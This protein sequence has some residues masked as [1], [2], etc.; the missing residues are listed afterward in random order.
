MPEC[1]QIEVGLDFVDGFEIRSFE[2]FVNM[3]D[4]R[5][6]VGRAVLRHVLAN[7]FEV[8]PVISGTKVS[9]IWMRNK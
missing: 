5:L 2:H 6:D 8:L 7:R 4:D 9:G 1:C 3:L